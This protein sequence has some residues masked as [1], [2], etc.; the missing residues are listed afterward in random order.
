M[1]IKFIYIQATRLEGAVDTYTEMIIN[2]RFVATYEARGRPAEWASQARKARRLL[3]GAE[4]QRLPQ[5]STSS[6]SP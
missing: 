4:H 2:Q 5:I 1:L 6:C 3:K